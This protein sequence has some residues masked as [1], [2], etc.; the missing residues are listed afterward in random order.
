[1]LDGGLVE[2]HESV[3]A[4]ECGDECKQRTA[5]E[6]KVGEQCVGVFEGVAGLDEEVGAGGEVF[7]GVGVV[8]E[9][10]DGADG[11]GA[12]GDDTLVIGSGVVEL[13]NGGGFDGDGFIMHGVLVEVVDTD[14]GEGAEPDVEGD[15]GLGDAFDGEGV[16]HIFGEVEAGGGGGDGSGLLGVNG[17][18]AFAVVAV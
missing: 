5:R 9:R 6:V 17:L 11:G 3:E 18:V 13:L 4:G 14:G 1:M 12:D 10:F 16:E 2:L 15:V 7:V 8:G